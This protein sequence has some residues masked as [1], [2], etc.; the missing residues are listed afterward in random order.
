MSK[1]SDLKATR[2]NCIPSKDCRGLKRFLNSDLIVILSC[3][4]ISAAKRVGLRLDFGEKAQFWT[5][6][7]LRLHHAK[8]FRVS[9]LAFEFFN[10]GPCLI[11]GVEV[12]FHGWFVA[13]ARRSQG[14]P[15]GHAGEMA[16]A[17]NVNLPELK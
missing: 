14:N 17:I 2:R 11:L 9:A 16:A 7:V 6:N 3:F 15:F 8:V 4:L 5:F 10:F 13:L 1:A 12:R